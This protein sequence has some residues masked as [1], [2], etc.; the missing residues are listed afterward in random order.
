MVTQKRELKTRLERD[1]WKVVEEELGD[2]WWVD[3]RW[4]VESTRSPPG[5]HVWVSFLVDPQHDGPRDRGEHVWAVGVTSTRPGARDQVEGTA[6]SI[7]R[8]WAQSLD[9]LAASVARIRDSVAASY[10]G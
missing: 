8:H 2:E 5:L 6:V 3:E 7:R 1:G 4:K 9:E 10:A